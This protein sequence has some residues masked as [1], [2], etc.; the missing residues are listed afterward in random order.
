[1]NIRQLY[2]KAIALFAALPAIAQAKAGFGSF[3]VIRNFRFIIFSIVINISVLVDCFPQNEN[4]SELI[5]LIAEELA[6]GESDQEAINLYIEQLHELTENPVKINSADE[7][8]LSRLFFLSDFQVKSLSD[9]ISRSGNIVSVF[10]IAS[11]PGFDRQTAEMM[12]PFI[13]LS[14]NNT[15]NVDTVRFRSTLLL[16]FIIKPGEKDT[17][18]LGSS[19]KLLSKYRFTAGRFSGGFT[20]EK[21]EGEKL[22][23]FVS[24]YLA[25]SGKGVIKKIIAGDFSARFGQGTSI[26]TGIRTGLSLTTPGYMAARNEIRPY[27]STDENNFFRGIAAQL[28]A[29][30]AGMMIFFSH[31][32][33][34]ATT[35]N[36]RDSTGI[37]VERFYETGLHNTSSMLLKKNAVNETSY[38]LNLTFNFHYLKAGFCL[39]ESRYSIPVIPDIS[40]PENLYDFTGDIKR[41]FSFHY[42]SLVNKMLLYGEFSFNDI[43]KYAFVQGATL[44]PSDRLTVNF[45]YRNYSPGYTSFHGNGP[46]INSSDNNEKGFLGNFTFEAAKHLFISAGCDVSHFPW[47]KYR[48]SY[49]SS[50]RRTEIRIKYMPMENLSF[51]LAYN[52][53]YEM[54]NDDHT[55]GIPQIEEKESRWFKGQVKYGSGE[56]FSFMTRIDFKTVQSSGSTGML[57][58]QDMSYNFRQIPVT[59]WFRYCIFNTDDWD[60]RLYAYENDLLYSFSIPALSGRGSR[61][62]FMV[63][64][65]IGKRSEMRVKYSLTS[66]VSDKNKSEEKDELKLQFRVWF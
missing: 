54:L 13:D 41:I 58:L 61:S 15:R 35:S 63:K 29:G 51:E 23:D 45:I 50:A 26:N 62:Y 5:I 34:D 49:P 30:K 44:R 11:I 64:W 60:S 4:T 3:A 65:E 57:L 18:D 7:S 47:L 36:L 59:F 38:G 52:I 37:F 14:N 32:R 22:F 46:G 2:C 19:F 56:Q 8:E 20:T 53:R 27:T 17:S 10:E 31:N 12:I 28:C 40:D 25:F 42:N 66:L 21:D 24:G 55:Q 6:A 33:I 43:E 9:Y 48:C 39:S 16:N 1:M